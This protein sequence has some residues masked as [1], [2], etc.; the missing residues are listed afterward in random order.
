MV[1][2]NRLWGSLIFFLNLVGNA[3]YPSVTL[4]SPLFPL[5]TGR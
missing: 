1:R 3:L 2:R 4:R 5:C